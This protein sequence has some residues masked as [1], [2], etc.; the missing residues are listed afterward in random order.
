[1]IQFARF[2]AGF[3]LRKPGSKLSVSSYDLLIRSFEGNL[4][5]LGWFSF[6]CPQNE[7]SAF[8]AVPAIPALELGG[9]RGRGL[10]T[11]YDLHGTKSSH[12]RS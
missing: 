12:W 1:M 4:R 7:L 2:L 6:S 5:M 8:T 3:L 10:F 9:T 11:L